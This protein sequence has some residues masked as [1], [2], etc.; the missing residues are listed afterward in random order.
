MTRQASPHDEH[1]ARWKNPRRRNERIAW[2]LLTLCICVAFLP[3]LLGMDMM[4]GGYALV[5]SMGFAA[6]VCLIGALAYRRLAQNL[7]RLFAGTE[8]IA[9]WRIDPETWARFTQADFLAELSAKQ[10]LWRYLSAIIVVVSGV[11]L[12]LQRDRAAVW[13]ALGMVGLIGLLRVVAALVP[14]LLRRLHLRQGGRVII[15]CSGVWQGG[16]HHAWNT[17]GARLLR[18]GLEHSAQLDRPWLIL[19]YS[20]PSRSGNE[21]V[22]VRVPLPGGNAAPA[23]PVIEALLAANPAALSEP[24]Y[25]V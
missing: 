9:D 12:L 4:K 19:M 16:A 18:I 6:L 17:L 22:T 7:D 20:Y 13:V 11:F 21:T 3:V 2:G 25:P 1:S 10:A 8:T 23:R 24:M 15:G 14:R 5:W